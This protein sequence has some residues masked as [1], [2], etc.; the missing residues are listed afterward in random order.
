[1][2][3]DILISA[4][5]KGTRMKELSEHKPKHL[6]E[7]EGRPFL[8]YVLDNVMEAGFLRIY[9]VVG[10]KKERIEEFAKLHTYPIT[11][12]DQFSV[13][14][15]KYGTAVPIMSAE[16]YL[17]GKSFVSIAGD[18]YYSTRD[19]RI[20]R[21]KHDAFTYV[22]GIRHEH[23]ERMGVLVAKADMSLE[24][25]VEKPTEDLGNLI[26]TSLYTFTPRVYEALN[27]VGKSPR[28]EYEITDAVSYLA[29]RNEVKVVELSDRW[30]DFGRPEDIENMKAILQNQEVK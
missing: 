29:K 18:N 19:L 28:G 13:L 5:G 25:I 23:P 7:V 8:R 24:R 22:A 1:M 12:I 21:E 27:H 6:I 14:P 26:N 20:M 16:S 15:E 11:F 4:G 2:I 10:Y 3:T 17:A 30:M 9:L